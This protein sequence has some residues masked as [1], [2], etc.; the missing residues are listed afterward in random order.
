MIERTSVSIAADG[1]SGVVYSSGSPADAEEFAA[2][3]REAGAWVVE[4]RDSK[5][6]LV[7]R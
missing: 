4:V 5:G 6:Q 7:S 3:L 2:N 1:T